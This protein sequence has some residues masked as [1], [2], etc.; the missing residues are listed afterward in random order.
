MAA[1]AVLL[2]TKGL[3]SIPYLAPLNA[4]IILI[5]AHVNYRITHG[6]NIDGS[7]SE[8]AKSIYPAWTADTGTRCSQD[9]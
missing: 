3:M 4:R 6:C 1:A 8:H 2:T 7:A 9:Q 5:A